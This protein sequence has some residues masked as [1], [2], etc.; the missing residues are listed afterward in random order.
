MSNVCSLGL[1]AG[2]FSAVASAFIIDVQS[3]LQ[4]D[5]AGDTAALLRVL[6][7]KMDNTTFGADTPTI[8]Q[9]TGPPRAMVQVQ[10][11]LYAS[12][13]A[14][15]LSAFLAMLGKQWLNRYISTDMRGTA[16]ERS[17]NRQQKL[18]G[19]VAWYFDHVMEALPLMLQA[20]LLLLGCALSR[21]L[22]GINVIVASVII[23]VTSFGI[24]F[25]IFILVAGTASESCPYQTPG[26][27]A[28][29]Y[30][31]PKARNVL[32]SAAVTKAAAT[33]TK[34][35]EKYRL[36]WSRG[37][38]RLVLEDT[39]LKIPRAFAVDVYRLGQAL[40]RK[41]AIFL[42][43]RA[44]NQTVLDLRCISW[45]LQT[46]LD[47]A[48]HLSTLKHLATMMTLADF[49]PTLVS[50]CLDVFTGCIKV[51]VNNG[52]MVIM[53]GL[54]QLAAVS[55]MCFLRTLHHLFVMDPDSSVLE[56]VCQRYKKVFPFEPNFTGLPFCYTMTK[57]HSL[58]NQ[59]WNPHTIRWDDHEPST[60]EYISFTRGVAEAAQVEYRRSEPQEVP[61][62]IL[63]FAHHS[64]SLYPVPPMSVVGDCLSIVAIDLGC[65]VLDTGFTTLD[66]GCVRISSQITNTLTLNQR[67]S[68]AGCE[69]DYSETQNDGR[70]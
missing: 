32:L 35:A 44:Q 25:Y 64:L 57:I 61:G 36:D 29:R 50:G 42:A 65:E 68:W 48:V 51:D 34:N 20:A 53:Q 19:I 47:G 38:V 60:Q 55:A 58:A 6:I 15:L 12:L 4:P 30:L 70:S 69:L 7:Y 56:D 23:C 33:V 5:A 43:H 1:Q 3:N 13:A 49:D 54:E 63:R 41:L 16:I 62:W 37:S 59:R 14:S 8:P 2:L 22:W 11:I 52:K 24:I 26:S 31:A 40:T 17:Q 67:T 27:R 10:A 66:E 21:Y 18:D 46:S 39:L 45:M 9:W 28:L